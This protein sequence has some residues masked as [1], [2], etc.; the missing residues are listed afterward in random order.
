MSENKIGKDMG[1]I[2]SEKIQDE[3]TDHVQDKLDNIAEGLRG[4]IK[5]ENRKGN[6]HFNTS[7]SPKNLKSCIKA[8]FSRKKEEPLS[9]EEIDE[10]I[11][12]MKKGMQIK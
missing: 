1:K 4:Y 9:D 2:F 6:V 8:F 10:I 5:K 7:Q 11:D 3:V 12:K